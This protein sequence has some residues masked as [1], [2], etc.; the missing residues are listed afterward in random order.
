MQ[1]Y[2]TEFT[3]RT[4]MPVT[5]EVDA[6][7]N[8]PDVYKITLYRL[9]QESL[10]NIVKHANATHA[11]VDLSVEDNMITLTI[12]DNGKGFDTS[13]VKSSGIGLSSMNERVTIAG[14][15]LKITSAP[16]RGTI[17]SAQFALP[18]T[19]STLEKS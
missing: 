11:W 19:T 12:Q 4:H 14:G 6:P 1:T 8:L 16:E 10:N 15:T 3:R 17:L 2:C 5:C 9:L 18:E 7:E 13:E